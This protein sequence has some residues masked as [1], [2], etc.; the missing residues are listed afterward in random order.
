MIVNFQEIFVAAY[1]LT[2]VGYDRKLQQQI[3]YNVAPRNVVL[4]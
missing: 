2:T 1:F 4:H 3:V